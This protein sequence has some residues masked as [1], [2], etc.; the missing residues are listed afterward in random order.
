MEL[1]PE[2]PKAGF[3]SSRGGGESLTALLD[4]DSLEEVFVR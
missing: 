4:K 3:S 2:E 1:G